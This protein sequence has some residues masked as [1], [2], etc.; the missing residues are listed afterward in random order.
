MAHIHQSRP[1]RSCLGELIQIDGSPH[2]WFE[3]RGSVCCLLVFVDDATGKIMQLHFEQNE[4]SQGYFDATYAYILAHGKPVAFYSDR[5]GIFKVTAKEVEKG[6]A[7]TQFGRA[8]RQLDIGIICAN[9]P[10]A[11]GR[12]ENKNGTLQDRLVKE[13]RLQ[14]ISDIETA[15][16]YLPTFI[17]DYNRRFAKEAACTTDQHREKP[18]SKT[19]L[20]RT[21]SHQET[22]IISKNLEVHYNGKTYQIQSK[23]PSYTMRKAKV[24]VCE[25]HNQITLWYKGKALL[26]RVFDKN[27]NITMVGSSKEVNEMVDRFMYGPVQQTTLSPTIP[28]SP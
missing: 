17:E 3:E 13:L 4:S 28:A 10:Q 8:L 16:A 27:Q 6:E 9:T 5:H 11:K 12:V 14:G 1:R 7:E 25:S 24:L 23:T 20:R 21:L 22:R 15:N 2:A 18:V 26:Y 19:E